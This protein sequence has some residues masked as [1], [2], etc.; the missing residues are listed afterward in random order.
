MGTVPN[1]VTWNTLIACF[2]QGND[3]LSVAKLFQLVQE[4]GIDPD[5]VSWTSLIS[6]FVH[7]YQNCE[8]S[9]SFKKMLSTGMHPISATISSLWLLPICVILADSTHGK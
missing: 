7:N 9:D 2:S 5:V 4:A 1:L 6:G 8:A 3:D